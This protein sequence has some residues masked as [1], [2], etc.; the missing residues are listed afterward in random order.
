MLNSRVTAQRAGQVAR[1]RNHTLKDRDSLSKTIRRPSEGCRRFDRRGAKQ[2]LRCCYCAA[3]MS[4]QRI[5]FY[6]LA[7][8]TLIR[9]GGAMALNALNA[10]WGVTKHQNHA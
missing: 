7:P 10:A 9:L 2:L 4:A 3:A 8:R 1:A 6:K 5:P